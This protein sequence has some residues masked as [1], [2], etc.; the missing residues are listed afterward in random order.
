MT[1]HAIDQNPYAPPSTATSKASAPDGGRR[2]GKA[3]LR[4][5]G[6]SFSLFALTSLAMIQL[7][8]QRLGHV[9]FPIAVVLALVGLVLGAV[10]GV[11][12]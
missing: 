2:S 7:E 11:Q 8:S 4:L 9:G 3:A 12:S 1:D 6:A 10:S 5:L